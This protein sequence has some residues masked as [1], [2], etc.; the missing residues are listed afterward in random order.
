MDKPSPAHKSGLT[1]SPDYRRIGI[2]H[3]VLL[4]SWGKEKSG[5]PAAA[6]PPVQRPG[7]AYHEPGAGWLDVLERGS[8]LLP[9]VA[10][11]SG[12]ERTPRLP[13]AA[14]AEPGADY[15]LRAAGTH[16]LGLLARNDRVLRL[17]AALRFGGLGGGGNNIAV[18]KRPVPFDHI[19]VVGQAGAEEMNQ[20]RCAVKTKR[21]KT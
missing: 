17:A 6:P 19:S 9:P 14:G 2:G 8:A 7:Q 21:R 15:D 18:R 16:R 4:Y 11:N 13:A 5:R 20:E 1:T 12:G 3:A 10:K